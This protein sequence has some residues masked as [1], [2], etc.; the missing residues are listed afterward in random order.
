LNPSSALPIVGVDTLRAQVRFTD[1]IEP[2]ESAFA[3]TS[4]GCAENGLI[5]TFPGASR[6]SGDV[7]VKS[8]VLR[9]HRIFVVKISPWFAVNVAREQPQGGFL[10]A[11]D[12][13]TGHTVAI[14]D[15]RHYLSDIRT[16]AAGAVVARLLCRAQIR[17]AA[18]LG[19]GTQ[20]Y[21]QALALYHERPF[22]RLTIWARDLAK[23][24]Q[25]RGRLSGPLAGVSIAV[26]GSLERTVGEADVIVTATQAREAIV[27][28]E[29][30]QP[31]QHLTAVG[32]DDPAKCELHASVLRRA[33][34]FVDD[35]DTAVQN[36][37]VYRA[38]STGDYSASMLAGD[39]GGLLC[40]RVAGR[41]S[42]DQ[43]TVAKL[44]G[45]GAQDL[46]AAE[47]ALAKVGV[48]SEEIQ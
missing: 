40:G 38:I 45:I 13:L 32:A 26:E 1:L 39:I 37:D 25:L 15:E 4:R 33:R 44:I 21:W 28:G 2:V 36:G 31:G 22:R 24:E 23:G 34:V 18:V 10:A 19:A 27:H 3:Q 12:A 41:T 47:V 46:V 5:V 6:D 7:Y 43:V 17:Q 42:A 16:A 30:L 9:G 11:F 20:A 14:L 29:W 8:G 35:I 48:L